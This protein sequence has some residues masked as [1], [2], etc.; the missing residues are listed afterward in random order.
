L[1]QAP[2][3]SLDFNTLNFDVSHRLR[4]IGELI[5]QLKLPEGAPILDVGGH[6]GLLAKTF[7]DLNITT[8]DI[9][10]GGDDSYVRAA[11]ESLPFPD[12]T[13]DVAI[14]CDVLEHV[15]PSRREK[16]LQELLRV[17]RTAVIV[18]GPYA[19]PGTQRAEAIAVEL[20]PESYEARRW[21]V[22]HQTHGLPY[23]GE[24]MAI[25]AGKAHGIRVIP[26][27]T[28]STWLVFFAAEAAA[29]R[30][31]LL[32]EDLRSFIVAHNNFTT[33]FDMSTTGPAYRHAVVA[34]LA[35]DAWN[36]L[37]STIPDVADHAHEWSRVEDYIE[38]LGKLLKTMLHTPEAGAPSLTSIDEAYVTRLE[39]MLAHRESPA[40][41]LSFGSRLKRAWAALKGT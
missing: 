6:P 11:G 22:E 24:P 31:H 5:H 27:D 10:P 36:K 14:A 1:N 33:A 3:P 32:A 13:F 29:E 26:A 2:L 16:F 23:V 17:S 7:P 39:Q 40:E 20:L 9:L 8:T 38:S 18:A 19:T 25:F 4:H 30:R 12:A 34:A 35:A 21:L 37:S 15:S 41:Q 28:L